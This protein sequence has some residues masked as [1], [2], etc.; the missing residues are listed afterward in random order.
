M[1]TR[2]PLSADAA[3][4]KCRRTVL[5]GWSFQVKS[6]QGELPDHKGFSLQSSRVKDIQNL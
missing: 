6:L 5:K 2:K 4:T 1:F 3:W